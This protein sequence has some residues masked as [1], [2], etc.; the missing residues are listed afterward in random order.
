M[1]SRPVRPHRKTVEREKIER[2]GKEGE[3]GEKEGKEQ[4][5]EEGRNE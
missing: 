2:G 1:S 5:R 4:G 3:I